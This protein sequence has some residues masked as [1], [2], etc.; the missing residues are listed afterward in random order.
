MRG[1]H[2]Q[3]P[4][5][6]DVGRLS[7]EYIIMAFQD[8]TSNEDELT[9][10]ILGNIIIVLNTA[11]RI[12]GCFYLFVQLLVKAVQIYK[13]SKKTKITK[14]PKKKKTKQTYP[15]YFTS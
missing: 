5:Y 8:A 12:L 2:P 9:R 11:F 1:E 4:R 14:H 15:Y 6:L 7:F 3:W 13:A 10:E